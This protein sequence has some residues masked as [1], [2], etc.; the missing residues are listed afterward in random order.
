MSV[1]RIALLP[2][3]RSRKLP[4]EPQSGWRDCGHVVAREIL[5][6]SQNACPV[7]IRNNV[8]EFGPRTLCTVRY[9]LQLKTIMVLK[10]VINGI[11]M[12]AIKL[13]KA[14]SKGMM[15]KKSG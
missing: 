4:G 10:N 3:A 11:H 9:S 8:H 14:L 13:Y 6:S 1:F 2:M 15:Y 12:D 7:P 5:H